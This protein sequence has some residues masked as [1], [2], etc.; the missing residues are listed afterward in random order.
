MER[1]KSPRRMRY[2]ASLAE[3]PRFRNEAEEA[4]FW[5]SHSLAKIWNRLEPVQIEVAPDVRR[6]TLQQSR[7]KPVTLRLEERQIKRA[8]EI[9]REKSLNYQ[10]LLRTGIAEAIAREDR[11]RRR[12]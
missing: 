11:P 3:I 5:S 9:A 10:T 1:S 7:K 12:A 4:E 2:I 8:K 6:L